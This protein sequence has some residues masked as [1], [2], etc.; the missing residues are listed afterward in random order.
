MQCCLAGGHAL[1]AV[2]EGACSRAPAPRGT[3]SACSGRTTR[4]PTPLNPDPGWPCL[5]YALA[6]DE[7]EGIWAGT[8]PDERRALMRRFD[9]A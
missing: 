6:A 5:A 2:P 4:I 1:T 3:R 8:L 9:A 7:A